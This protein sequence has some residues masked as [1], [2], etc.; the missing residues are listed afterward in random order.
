MFS[1]RGERKGEERKK[2][3]IGERNNKEEKEE[4]GKLLC[5]NE[6]MGRNELNNV[7]VCYFIWIGNN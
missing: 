3:E 7:P 1:T 2:R 5:F 6:K 4:G